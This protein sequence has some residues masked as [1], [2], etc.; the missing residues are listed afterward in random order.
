MFASP[1]PTPCTGLASARRATRRA[2]LVLA[3]VA[4]WC[5][6]AATRIVPAF[7]SVDAPPRLSDGAPNIWALVAALPW[8]SALPLAGLAMA[9]A[10]GVTAWLA[11]HF[12]ARPP[13]GDTLLS[14]ALLVS[15]VLPGLLPQMQSGDFLP[16]LVLSGM[17]AVLQRQVAIA[18]LVMTGWCLAA[19][20]SNALGAVPVVVASVLIVRPFLAS[21]ANDNG[22]PLNPS[23]PYPA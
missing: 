1:F 18:A 20:G 13:R 14:A 6:S 21:P 9:T 8:A 3:L 10:L 5:G 17:L 2:W 23:V 16:A 4:L 12:S 11:A 15:L 7:F 22:L 19:A